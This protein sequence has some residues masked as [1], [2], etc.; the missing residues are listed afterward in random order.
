MKVKKKRLDY[1]NY[2][3]TSEQSNIFI[4]TVIVYHN[5]HHLAPY[6]PVINVTCDL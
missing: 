3:T 6:V 2:L 5:S 1:P 4:V